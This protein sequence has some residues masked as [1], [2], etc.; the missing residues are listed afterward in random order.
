MLKREQQQLNFYGIWESL[1]E[2][3]IQSHSVVGDRIHTVDTVNSTT[4]CVNSALWGLGFSERDRVL[5]QMMSQFLVFKVFHVDQGVSRQGQARPN[6]NTVFGTQLCLYFVYDFFA[7]KRPNWLVV[8]QLNETIS[9]RHCCLQS[10]KFL[11][12]GLSP[13]K[14]ADP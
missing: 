6:L 2:G 11:L 14:F 7:Q 4:F 12:S 8:T 1:N 3:R 13:K 9:R 10:L 5:S